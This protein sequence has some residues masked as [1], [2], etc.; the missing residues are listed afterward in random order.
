[1]INKKYGKTRYEIWNWSKSNLLYLHFFGCKYFIHSNGKNHLTTLDSKYD[2]GI[3][4]GYSL[5]SKAFRVFNNITL[6]I[7]KSILVVFDESY[8]NSEQSNMNDLSIRME[9]VQ[10]QEESE[11][12][13]PKRSNQTP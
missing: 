10:L 9:N 12:G 4:L 5:V 3:F 1:M 8:N 6:N 11:Y 7:E 2:V 13:A